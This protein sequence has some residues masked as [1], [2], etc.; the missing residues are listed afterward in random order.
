MADTL[1][2]SYDA[3][4][5]SAQIGPVLCDEFGEGSF[6]TV[7]RNTPEIW[8]TKVGATGKVSRSKVKDKSGKVTLVFPQTAGNVLKRLEV[9]SALD[10]VFPMMIK[11]TSDS[12]EF[13]VGSQ[14]WVMSISPKR[15]YA[16]EVSNREVVV[17]VA[18]LNSATLG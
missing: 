3:G 6:I 12:K 11:N 17:A 15:E 1:I 7:E 13:S 5:V 9:L 2:G 8:K 4:K 14:C 10:T 16:E 18:D